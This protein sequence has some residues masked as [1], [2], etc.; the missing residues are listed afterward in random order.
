[1]ALSGT[2]ISCPQEAATPNPPELEALTRRTR[3]VVTLIAGDVN[4]KSIA[5]SFNVS[6]CTVRHHLTSNFEELNGHEQQEL[7]VNGFR[8][9][10]VQLPPT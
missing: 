6:D 8:H 10:L 5:A 4:N 2:G 9:K 7:P 1:V 3:E